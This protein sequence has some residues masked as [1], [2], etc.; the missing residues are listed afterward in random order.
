HDLSTQRQHQN[1]HSLPTR[2]SSDLADWNHKADAAAL[3]WSDYKNGP[4]GTFPHDNPR[5]CRWFDLREEAQE[6]QNRILKLLRST[7]LDLRSEEHTSELQS[8]ERLVCRLLL[9]K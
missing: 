8:R 4:Q 5:Y 3:A 7:D 1:L 9:E 2:R 6:A